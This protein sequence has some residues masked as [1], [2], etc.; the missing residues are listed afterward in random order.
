V[1]IRA[2][3]TGIVCAA[4]I[5][6]FFAGTWYE[7]SLPRPSE[8]THAPLAAPVMP[9]DAAN[10]FPRPNAPRPVDPREAEPRAVEARA[11]A[12]QRDAEAIAAECERSARGDWD[13]WERD[14]A[15]SRAALRAKTDSLKDLDPAAPE[16]AL[17]KYAALEGRQNFPLF[18]IGARNQLNYLHDP[19][20][21]DAFRRDRPVVA[22]S[23]WLR[24]RGIDLILVSVPKMT[25]VYVEHFVDPCPSDGVIA[26]HFRR[27]LLELLKDDVEVVD[28]F[29]LF[30]P[31]RDTDAEYL[32]N[33][34]DTHWAPRALRIMAKYLADRVERY[35]FGARAR[36]ALPI[37]RTTLGL[38]GANKFSSEFGKAFPAQNGWD[39][40][41]PEQQKRA[42]MAQTTTDEVSTITW[43]GKVLT[44]DPDSPVLVMGHS[45][46][47]YFRDHLARALNM[48]VNVAWGD[49]RTT[50]AFADFLREPEMLAR[51]RVVV[52][53]TT[54]HHMTCFHPLPAEVA[55]AGGM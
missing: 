8:E 40:L 34:A 50:E 18:E 44:R 49:D 15:P 28:G 47:N 5:G 53:I 42:V 46:V 41:S 48:P 33:T 24:Q 30:R 39:S 29:R 7:A 26:P 3:V 32:Y 22:A 52:W 55:A 31:F 38:S 1:I 2:V 6:S 45:Y 35:R 20:S 11:E 54:G 23:R 13:R 37:V 36:Y 17:A 12:I 4:L 25:E 51:C 19:A 43:D 16:T 9:Y 10:G 27:T 21:L 14:T